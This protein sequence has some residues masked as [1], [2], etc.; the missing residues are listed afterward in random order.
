MKEFEPLIP[1]PPNPPRS[2]GTEKNFEYATIELRQAT[3][4]RG[5]RVR[6][7]RGTSYTSAGFRD[8]L[9]EITSGPFS[10]DRVAYLNM[11]G[12]EDDRGELTFAR[13]LQLLT[14]A[15]VAALEYERAAT[16][17]TGF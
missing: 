16:G 12:S 7:Y 15:Y 11:N 6:L 14:N 17:K 9:R 8:A 5:L 4:S 2:N 3:D 13:H 1:I 10:G